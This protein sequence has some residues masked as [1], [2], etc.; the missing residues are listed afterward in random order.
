MHEELVEPLYQPVL[1]LLHLRDLI[2]SILEPS[3]TFNSSL[4]HYITLKTLNVAA[5]ASVC[6]TAVYVRDFEPFFHV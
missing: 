1:L 2:P 5:Y 6:K 4:G 3:C